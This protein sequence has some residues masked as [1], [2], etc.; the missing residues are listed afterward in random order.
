[1]LEK[2]KKHLKI[3]FPQL[4]NIKFYVAVSGG[5]DSMV[6]VH[7]LQ[8]SDYYFGMLHCNFNLR[9]IESDGDM[10]FVED[11]GDKFLIPYSIG[12]FQTKK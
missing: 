2:F 1:M 10:K 6:L 3:N 4:K 7:L 5:I 9:G 8:K 12:H 11:Y